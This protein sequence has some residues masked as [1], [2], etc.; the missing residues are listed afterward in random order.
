MQVAVVPRRL[1]NSQEIAVRPLHR[2][3]PDADVVL[4]ARVDVA[5]YIRQLFGVSFLSR[6]VQ[7]GMYKLG[8]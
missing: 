8:E 7:T 1:N 2:V 4:H 3:H 6:G 5:V